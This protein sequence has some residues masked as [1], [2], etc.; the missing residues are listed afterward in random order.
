MSEVKLF[1]FSDPKKK[2]NGVGINQ[3][4]SLEFT[5]ESVDTSTT[6]DEKGSE[7]TV[8][9]TIT[10]HRTI[11][12]DLVKLDYEK[13]MYEPSVIHA[14]LSLAGFTTTTPIY[15][16]SEKDKDGNVTTKEYEGHAMGHD[17]T[18]FT[19]ENIM[20]SFSNA[21][22]EM[23]IDGK[24]VATNYFVYK[25]RSVHKRTAA[26][27]AYVELTIFSED[28]LLTLEKYSKAYTA[29]KLGTDIFSKEIAKYNLTGDNDVNL[30]LLTYDSDNKE[31][32]QPYLVQ[33]NESFYD[34]LKRTAN[35]CG[36]FLYHEDG[37]LHLGVDL[38]RL[39]QDTTDESTKKTVK[40]VDYAYVAQERNYESLYDGSVFT[41]DVSV[42]DYAYNYLN[43]KDKDASHHASSENGTFHYNDPLTT[44][45][46]LG[47][48]GMNYTSYLGEMDEI[49]KI[50]MS[51]IL[52]A[53]TGTSFS[54][55]LDNMAIELTCNAY[56]AMVSY[57]SKNGDNKEANITPWQ[58]ENGDAKSGTEDQWDGTETL[59]QFG[60]YGDKKS[61]ISDSNVNMNAL[62]YSLVR[63]AEKKVGE[64]AVCLEFGEDA[65]DLHLGN[66][67]KVEGVSFVIVKISGL[68]EYVS[69]KA[70]TVMK[71]T[72]TAIPL[73]TVP[74]TSTTTT[75]TMIAIPYALAEENVREAHP[76]LA[77]VVENLDPK[78][79]GRVRIRFAWQEEDAD[80]S[81]WIRVSLPFATNGGGIK[82]KPEKGDEVL[83]N[84]EEGNVE[85]PYVSGYLLSERSNEAWGS[86]SDRS[87]VSKNG[88]SITFTDGPG[89]DFLYKNLLPALGVIKSWVPTTKWPDSL[90]D[91][92][93][94]SAL[95]GG[96][97]IRDQYGLYEISASSDD[98]TVKIESAMGNVTLNAFTGITV[99]AP[100]GNIKIAGKNVE[101][102]ASNNLKLTS[103]SA[104][105]DRFFPNSTGNDCFGMNL[106]DSTV[107]T[108]TDTVAGYAY[109][110]VTKVLG[111]LLDLSLIR[112]VLEIALRPIDGTTSIKSYTFVQIEAGKG[113]V[114]M[115]PEKVVKTDE[116][117]TFPDIRL[118][119]SAISPTVSNQVDAIAA[120][121][122]VLAEKMKNYTDMSGDAEGLLNKGEG[123]INLATIKGKGWKETADQL[124]DDDA[125][126]K[127]DSVGLKDGEF[128]E[129]D[130]IQ[131]VKDEM[132]KATGNAVSEQ[133]DKNKDACYQ[134][135]ADPKDKRDFDKDD[136]LWKALYKE[137]H[138]DVKADIE[139]K[140]AEKKESRKKV[141]ACVNDLAT[142]MSGVFNAF[143]A[144]DNLSDLTVPQPIGDE[145]KKNKAIASIKKYKDYIQKSDH[146][147]FDS[148]ANNTFDKNTD[149]SQTIGDD[150]KKR[151]SRNA[152]LDYMA[153]FSG[154]VNKELA[155]NTAMVTAPPPLDIMNDI[156]WSASIDAWFT[157]PKLSSGQDM[158]NN[159]KDKG[160]AYKDWVMDDLFHPWVTTVK[161]F[162]GKHRWKTGVHGKIL[163]SDSPSATISFD[164][165][166]STVKQVN[167]VASD[168]Y[169]FELRD[170]IKSL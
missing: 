54:E 100:N 38:K 3:T 95:A 15:K 84:F 131:K 103:G 163:M 129:K 69:E 36:E 165:D 87:I 66:V 94:C 60:T 142:A 73:Y 22:A 21:K 13:K 28:K 1:I 91:S 134:D 160:I 152:I 128:K 70:T 113:S 89:S 107:K 55:I 116:L 81:P 117:K 35:R 2:G 157:E 159:L 27:F 64:E 74:N 150:V 41:D 78:K 40:A 19:R 43:N 5:E 164:R 61:Q 162:A 14:T 88:H 130:A 109:G 17:S 50:A 76:Q 148:L 92:A 83:V 56:Q 90:E 57:K 119:L 47:D 48:I 6:K 45:D 105:K 143:K 155:G 106:L 37:K 72:V 68:Y 102:S 11:T 51:Q 12:A 20:S 7:V 136:D 122:K 93:T 120:A 25:V 140:N 156:L 123:A 52:M 115:P 30:Q 137:F 44:D 126:F 141:V 42:E 77:F 166:G 82:F 32:R 104:L 146:A 58:D 4:G 23:T 79:I 132:K 138:D 158:L 86:L 9:T 59:R 153:Y 118:T 167:S 46:Y 114:E 139:K 154:E 53:L 26:N 24:V 108:V 96:I 121:A 101:I 169:L 145:E 170:Y 111:S 31:L 97:K 18:E 71:Q 75:T 147:L 63:K 124:Q 144:V 135:T 49:E 99:S 65:Q 133:P 151:W 125:A 80:A 10:T 149:F 62:F 161:A 110:L 67:I 33:Y 8:T 85:R 98:R 127:W 112:T 29:K 39:D 34:F 168:K 16:V